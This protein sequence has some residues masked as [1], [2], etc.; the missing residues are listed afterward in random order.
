MDQNGVKK[1]LELSKSQREMQTAMAGVKMSIGSALIPVIS[2]LASVLKPVVEAFAMLVQ[3]CP[4]LVP[5]ILALAAALVG[6]MI[7]GSIAGAFSALAAA[8]GLTSAA[9]LGLIGTALVAAAPFIAIGLAIVALVALFVLLYNKVGWFHDAVD[10][11]WNAIV[12]GATAAFNWITTAAQTAFN[13]IKSNW[14]LLLAILGGPFGLAV[15]IIT[16]HFGKIKQ[17][18]QDV[19]SAIAGIFKG[20]PGQVAGVGKAIV[21]AIASGISSGAG[22]IMSA[23]ESILPGPLKKAVGGAAG[24]FSKI[25]GTGGIIAAQGGATLGGG[26][27]VLVGERG[28]E[29]ATMPAGTR[30]TP[31]PP[32]MLSPSQLA[33]GAT[34]PIITQV[35]LERRMIAEALGSF[36]A[37]QQAA[38]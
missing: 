10:A 30:I 36:T 28:P 13:W 9:L 17:A 20:L 14:P 21:D 4:I 27:T 25:M 37:E 32:P 33:G 12:T 7:A 31:L 2:T 23:I 26:G 35:F 18:A 24:L 22:A 19:V 6:L 38:R 11:V 16:G 8:F 34:R 29:L 15:A 5:V 1:A 3:K